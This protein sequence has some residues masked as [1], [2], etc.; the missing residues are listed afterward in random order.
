M[1]HRSGAGALGCARLFRAGLVLL[2]LLAFAV[3]G[4]D[5]ARAA[6]VEP[7]AQEGETICT[8]VKPQ[9]K[10]LPVAPPVLGTH[11]FDDGTLSGSYTLGAD[12]HLS[13][14][15]NDLP[16]DY[17]LVHA[18]GG[19]TNYYQYPDGTKQD[20]ELAAPNGAAIDA[21]RFCYDNQNRGRVRIVKETDPAGSAQRFSFHPSADL[22]P[23]DFDLADGESV[24]FRPKPGT[25]SVTEA[26]A[27][28]WKV[29]FISCDD[30]NSSGAG[31]IATIVVDPGETITCTF[32]NAQV[33]PVIDNPKPQPQPQQTPLAVVTP[34]LLVAVAPPTPL[35][36]VRGAAVRRGTARLRRPARCVTGAFRVTVAGSPV[37]RIEFTVNGRRVR[38]VIARNG[39]R[40]FS[41]ALPVA[42]GTVQR[43]AA[44]VVFANG[45]GS[46][47]LRATVLRCVPAVAP[48]FTG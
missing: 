4:A 3:L 16:V 47:T 18:T 14:S 26:A 20:G 43:V 17:V 9:R 37:R 34:P 48:Q 28:G 24:E 33:P 30:A 5:R 10:E 23:A 41:V 36:A 35:L 7:I 19:A 22:A 13:W 46:R 2:A 27:N 12:N 8:D 21:V 32:V 40:S 44:R 45:A 15:S 25:Y 39:Q 29:D 1:A 42:K 31:S 6:S 11:A 38:T